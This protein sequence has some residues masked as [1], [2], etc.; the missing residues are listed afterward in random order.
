MLGY[1]IGSQFR[2]RRNLLYAII[3]ITIISL[4]AAGSQVAA[5]SFVD[6]VKEFLGVKSEQAFLPDQSAFGIFPAPAPPPVVCTTAPNGMISWWA[7]EN[8]PG[9]NLNRNNGV[10]QGNAGFVAGIVGNA[11]DLDGTGDYVQITSPTGLPVGNSARTV[12]LWFRAPATPGESGLFQYGSAATGQMFG[13][14][15]SGNA[16]GRLYFYGHSADLASATAIQPNTWYHGAVTYD[17][18]T[19]NVFVNGILENSAPIALNTALNTNGITIGHRAG[20]SFWTGQ[21]DEPT[22]YDRA[23]SAAEILAIYNA[24]SAGKCSECTPSPN[25]IV[26]WWGG[27]GNSQ[28]LI[29]GNNGTLV[30]GATFAPGKVDQ[31]FSLNQSNSTYVDLPAAT[32][33]LLNNSAGSIS[34]WV[35]PSAVGDNDIVAAFGTG[36][37]GE[38]VGIGIYGNVRIY[39]HTSTY[40]WQSTTPISANAWTHITYTWDSTTERIYKDG[41]LSESRPRNFNYVPGSA[42]IGHGWWGDP[43][44]YFP[45]LI[46]EVDIYN[47]TL[48]GPEISAI[49]NA[50]SAGKCASCIPTPSGMVGWWKAN[51]NP[52]DSASGNN[53]GMINGATFAPGI[54]DQA[55]SLN[56]ATQQYVSL[57]DLGADSLL[58]NSNGS[59]SAWVKPATVSE[60][61]I[62]AAFGSGGP[63]QPVGL[64]INGNV[65]IYHQGDPYDWQTT[66]PV[67][68]NV[69][70]LLTYTW[71]TT[72]EKVYKNGLLADTRA[73]NFTYAPGSSR[74]G[75]G[76]INDPSVFYTG[77]IDELSIY[78]RTLDASEVIAQY[79][80]GSLGMCQNCTPPP[81]NMTQWWPGDGNA[82]DIQG[83]TFENGTLVNGTT[84]A[85]GKVAQ[86]ISFDGVDDRVDVTGTV[87]DFGSTPF[88]IDLWLYSNNVGNGAY[89]LGK[90]HP[91]GGMGWDI[92]LHDQRI[93]LEGTDGW[94][95]SFNWESDQSVTPNGWHHLAVTA[96]PSQIAVY[97]DGVLKGTPSRG[98]I[99]TAPNPFRL[100]F[101]TNYGGTPFN[102]QLDELEIFDRQLT[103][104]E[105]LAIYNA[106]SAG[107]C[108]PVCTPLPINGVSWWK[109]NG[110][111]N[112]TFG[113]N[114]GI[115]MNGAG[116]APGIVGQAFDFSGTDDYLQVATPVGL[117]VGAAPRTM[118]L[119]FKTPN[120]WA[121]TYPLMMQYGGTSP[122]SKFGLMAVDS[123]GRKL[124][125]WG[126]ANDLVGSTVLQTNTWYHGAVTYDGS[127]VKLYL[128]GL[129]ETSQAKSLNTFSGSDFTL[130]R[131]GS[132]SAITGEWNGLIDEPVIFSREL[133][134]AEIQAVF[135]AGSSGTCEPVATPT[136]TATP[137]L[138][139]TP[140]ATPTDT[141]TATPTATPT[142]EP[143]CVPVPPNTIAWWPGNG[144]ANDIKGPTFENGSLMNGAGFT[145]GLVGQAF[146]FD[147]ANDYVD[148]PDSASLDMTRITMSFWFKLNELGRNHELVNKFGPEG[149]NTIGYGS[150][151]RT[152]NRACFRLSTDG[153]LA[154]LTDLCST[155]T[156]ASGV[157]YHFAGTYDGS[158]MKLFINGVNEGTVGKTGNIFVNNESLRLGSYGYSFWLMNGALDEVS[159]ADRAFTAEE[160]Q[161]IYNAGSAGQCHECTPPPANMVSWWPGDGNTSDIIGSNNGIAEGNLSYSSAKVLQG[162]NFDG[163]TADIRIPA[164]TSLDVGARGAM[165]IDMW[166]KPTAVT[167]NPLAEW[168]SG[169]TGAHFWLGGSEVPGN[170]YINLTDTGGN[171]HVL[172]AAGGVVVPNEWQHVA[173]TYDSAS[174][175]AAIY[176]DGSIVAGPTNLGSFTPATASDLYLGFRINSGYRFSG[177][178]DEVELFDRALSQTEIQAIYNAG[179]AGKCSTGCVQPPTEMI[180]WWDGD[181]TPN[182]IIGTN[183][184]TLINGASHTTGM[185]GQAFD[186]TQAGQHVEIPDSQSLR[187]VNGLSIDGW[188]KFNNSNPQA[189]L[190]SKPFLSGS[191]NAYVIWIQGGALWAS[192][193]GAYVNYAFD[194]TPG[195]WYHIAY[196][197]DDASAQHWLFVDGSGVASAVSA[198]T[199]TYDSSP[200]LIGIDKDNGS[201]VLHMVGVA[202]EVEFFGRALT[203]NEILAIYRAGSAGKCKPAATPTPT[204]TPTATPTGTPTPTPT[205]TPGPAN[206]TTTVTS[207]HH[208]SIFG[209]SVTFTATVTSAAIPDS[210]EVAGPTGTVTF[211]IDGILYCINSPLN[212]SSFAQC[213]QAGLPAMAA[214][215]RNVVAVYSGD[216]NFLGSAGT[217]NQTVDKADTAI[218]ITGD[219]PDPSAVNQPYAVTWS[220][221]V[222]A[223]G[224]GTPTGN[225]TVADGAGGTCTAPIAVGTCNFTSA[226][227]GPKTLVAT[228]TGGANFN[229]SVS[230][231][232]SHTVSNLSIT[233]NVKLYV[234]GGPY[235]NLG[236]VS[237]TAA[238]PVNGMAITD[239]GGNYTLTGLVPGNYTVTPSSPGRVFDPVSRVYTGIANNI[240]GADFFAYDSV[241]QAPR[242]LT[243]ATET[244]EPGGVVSM[245][246]ILNAQGDEVMV[247]FSFGYDINPI[248]VAPTVVCG[249]DG[250]SCTVVTDTSILG[251]VGVTV[252]AGSG[253]FTRTEATGDMEIAL[254]NFQTIATSLPNTPI[255]FVAT[256]VPSRTLNAANDLL[257]TKYVPGWIVFAQGLEGDVAGRH[258]GSGSPDA[259]DVVQVRRF[260]TDLDIP[261]MEYNE[262][263]RADTAP[264]TTRGDGILDATD[265]IQTRRYAAGLDL[266]QEAGGLAA[267]GVLSRPDNDT[268]HIDGEKRSVIVGSTSAAAGS[269]IAV[270]VVLVPN[271]EESAI[272]FV[273]KYDQAKLG[274]PVIEL[275]DAFYNATLTA[276]TEEPGVIRVLVDAAAP[277]GPSSK[278]ARSIVNISLDVAMTAASGDTQLDIE[279]CVIADANAVAIAAAITSGTVSIAG[280]NPAGVEIGGR[281]LTSEGRGIRDVAVVLVDK[282]RNAR[283]VLTGTFGHYR[284]RG[285]SPDAWYLINARSRRFRFAPL[286][287][288]VTG[289]MDDVDLIA[290]E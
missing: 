120:S 117:P 227:I 116:Y 113:I 15:T 144:S 71:D 75:Y 252:T 182:D 184:G 165:T 211:N 248:A 278:E 78:N 224:A 229:G 201:P 124:Y 52:L 99:S 136:P 238:G 143:T 153:T 228:Y 235:P 97:I 185:V 214:G 191:S 219:S 53:G 16:P 178:M 158:Q 57:S 279:E 215:F 161:T 234:P 63:G 212:S 277:F 131:Y 230:A 192:V 210:P 132:N 147:G 29:S 207:S 127:T 239:A 68:A 41:A 9:D 60:F 276:N 255:D 30:N 193:N 196:T 168:G 195:R 226:T 186:F 102:G 90:S 37:A 86:A 271:A 272:S 267:A 64:G 49:Y 72:N 108:K 253:G 159:L 118:M 18:T 205:P 233:G 85:T 183:E 119:W 220:T 4:T 173:M 31:A 92:R 198:T 290:Q 105:I 44:N 129:S 202:D 222:T 94:A 225:L 93:R 217:F 151:V 13:L 241:N 20:G 32:S 269:R 100:G 172:Q 146:I 156:F 128:N 187:P 88:T 243:F 244:V 270:P 216:S 111:P 61:D 130:G 66:V 107:K 126:E 17:G 200:V 213:T 34:A 177:V 114:N 51:G 231:S 221:T 170:L 38:G 148:I 47:R 135:D 19:V 7:A 80:A 249:S 121:D 150:D 55:F 95:P 236:G 274:D 288:H 22:I 251:R 223:P 190:V 265:V 160:V 42:R 237:I 245:P 106:G 281:V 8:N 149:S 133:S 284:F 103:E 282:D 11:F 199:P 283:T 176:L 12:E 262:F 39:H 87:G 125:F 189:A 122:S 45:G 96:G 65:R 43:A 263:Q 232:E 76:F 208:P 197:Y 33:N 115:L 69:W 209:E 79:N 104:Q 171:Y 77:L 5:F 273:L 101:T 6:S 21:L 256:P 123:G 257:L 180:S 166:I 54:I 164:S 286:R 266:P 70:T 154:G 3:A 140:T 174:G 112:D 138:T 145:T 141:P 134:Q 155:T 74:I 289:P 163:T 82:N 179:S 25:G 203:G 56:Q 67:S 23:L 50:G 142:P 1:N 250:P 242:S 137:T 194:P 287:L 261:I 259:V 98:A 2:L 73:R 109:G 285:V 260:V 254:I 264:G 14:I 162:F 268:A 240:T 258:A 89:L 275:G 169:I 152:D 91:D 81:P 24:G 181:G 167:N 188:F 139:P 280:P 83:P 247:K 40:D 175:I 110:A 58:N 59:I 35:N 26:G 46:D 48:A 218:A 36:N 27:N 10:L 206:T 62:V 84:F 246:V 28:D 204:N 157:W